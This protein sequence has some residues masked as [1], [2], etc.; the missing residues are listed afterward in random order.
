MVAFNEFTDAQKLARI[1]EVL[2]YNK[3]LMGGSCPLAGSS[4]ISPCP[5]CN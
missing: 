2:R 3:E 5:V 4:D 1:I